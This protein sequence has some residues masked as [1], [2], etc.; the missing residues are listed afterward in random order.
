MRK[1]K[2]DRERQRGN[3]RQIKKQRDKKNMRNKSQK[4]PQTNKQRKRRK[5]I[6][7]CVEGEAKIK[8]ND[9]RTIIGDNGTT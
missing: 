1:Q 6:N 9:R 3:K 4:Q 5:K 8:N 7:G 2:I